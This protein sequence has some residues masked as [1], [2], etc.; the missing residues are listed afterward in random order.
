MLYKKM[1]KRKL[2]KKKLV[3]KK[4][5]KKKLNYN[6]RLYKKSQLRRM[7]SKSNSLNNT[8]IL[9]TLFNKKNKY[10]T[11]NRRLLKR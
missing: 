1:Y 2:N 3:K 10:K 5:N 8:R 7:T 4:L 11:N 9:R 6:K